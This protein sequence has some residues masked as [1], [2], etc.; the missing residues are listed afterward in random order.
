MRQEGEVEFAM[1]T[2]RLKSNKLAAAF[3]VVSRLKKSALVNL[4]FLSLIFLI[5][6]MN[7]L[8][9][10]DAPIVPTL[11][12]SYEYNTSDRDYQ[13]DNTTTDYSGCP[14]HIH[15]GNTSYTL[16]LGHLFSGNLHCYQSFNPIRQCYESYSFELPESYSNLFNNTSEM[17]NIRSQQDPII[18]YKVNEA[19]KTIR[20]TIK[21][22]EKQY[23]YPIPS[24]PD[25]YNSIMTNCNQNNITKAAVLLER[26]ANA[27]SVAANTQNQFRL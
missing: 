7:I 16:S 26:A 14:S 15:F 20:K 8:W 25:C 5:I 13:I 22:S 23:D 17:N 4:F 19:M 12:H 27:M 18:N 1:A 6:H 11:N 2:N 9:G 3:R 10:R 24:V 21:N